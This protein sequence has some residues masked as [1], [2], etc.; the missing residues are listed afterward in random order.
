MSYWSKKNAK[1]DFF[2]QQTKPLSRQFQFPFAMIYCNVFYYFFIWYNSGSARV[3]VGKRPRSHINKTLSASFNRENIASGMTKKRHSKLYTNNLN[4]KLIVCNIGFSIFSA[5]SLVLQ[6][7]EMEYEIDSK[8]C[9]VESFQVVFMDARK[10]SC[11]TNVRGGQHV[12][13]AVE[14][15]QNFL[16]QEQND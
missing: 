1:S 15:S 13:R 14:L 3:R 10:I 4:I 6:F 11:E 12:T 7:L 2:L 8:P 16:S 9:S 5:F